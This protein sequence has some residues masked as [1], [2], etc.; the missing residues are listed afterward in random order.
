VFFQHILPNTLQFSIIVGPGGFIIAFFMAW[1]LAQVQALPRTIFAL[2]LFSPALAG[3]GM[4]VLWTFIFNGNQHGLVN[5]M[6]LRWDMIE[7]PINFFQSATWLMPIMIGISLWGSLGIGFLAML[8]GILN[9][10]EEVYEAAYI[11]GIRNR[12]QEIIYI[13]I[14]SSMPQ[15]LFGAIM[16]ISGAFNGGG[17][18]VTLSGSNPTPHYA[19]SVITTHIQDFA[20]PRME[21]GYASALAVVLFGIVWIFAK[22]SFTLF[23]GS[24]D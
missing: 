6:L 8:A 2:C 19:G 16:A 9:V 10:N 18:G 7:T 1:L 21:I 22:V 23:G 15:M 11:D 24:D 12:F 14:P 17:I 13:T 5:S 3:G 20:G 4:M